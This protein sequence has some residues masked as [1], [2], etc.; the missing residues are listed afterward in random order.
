MQCTRTILTAIEH[1]PFKIYSC[2]L[3]SGRAYQSGVTHA[4]NSFWIGRLLKCINVKRV[5]YKY[6]FCIKKRL[7]C[8]C[9]WQ[10]Y[11]LRPGFCPWWRHQMDTFSA[12]LA[13]LC[14]E[15]T[16]HRWI[17]H[18]GQWRG[19]LMFS[20]ICAW[21][22]GWVNTRDTGDLIRHRPH[23]KVTVIFVV[24]AVIVAVL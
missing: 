11:F 19:V 14:G 2:R 5:H 12:L 3:E 22:N 13:P 9:L 17:P 7:F 24:D 23:Y 21:T 8:F 16:G 10:P 15:F 6:L 1:T 4:A 18:K 20:F